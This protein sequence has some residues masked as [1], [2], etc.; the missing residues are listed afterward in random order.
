MRLYCLFEAGKREGL[1]S[2]NDLLLDMMLLTFGI[3]LQ[4]P[5]E[6]TRGLRKFGLKANAH[7]RSYAR[8]RY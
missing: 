2:R 7:P 8:P 3:G 5:D 1:D 6:G 4:V